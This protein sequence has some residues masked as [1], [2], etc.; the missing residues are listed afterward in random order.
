[1]RRPVDGLSTLAMIHLAVLACASLALAA[2][3]Q[4]PFGVPG[5]STS[6]VSLTLPRKLHGRFL[7]ITDM[8]GNLLSGLATCARMTYPSVTF[9]LGGYT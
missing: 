8:A 3:S 7:H 6:N 9:A 1:M 4:Q 2:P 5:P